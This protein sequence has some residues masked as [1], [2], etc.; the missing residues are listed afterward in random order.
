MLIAGE[1]LRNRKYTLLKLGRD[2]KRV[3]AYTRRSKKIVV[4][5][6]MNN[7]NINEEA[8]VCVQGEI[9]T[10]REVNDESDNEL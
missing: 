1:D 8:V 6:L 4:G 9:I 7:P 10:D 3:V 2:G 5:V